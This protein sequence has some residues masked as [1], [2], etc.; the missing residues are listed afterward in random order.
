MK[1]L[2]QVNP[3]IVVEWNSVAVG[4]AI[5]HGNGHLSEDDLRSLAQALGRIA[6]RR[7]LALAREDRARL[8]T[9]SEVMPDSPVLPLINVT[10]PT[11]SSP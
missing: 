10:Q 4:Y 9:T 2:Q 5:E 6:A 1:K 3:A 8:A 11:R 7:D